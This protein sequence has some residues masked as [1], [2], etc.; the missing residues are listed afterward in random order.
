M[1]NNNYCVFIISYDRPDRVF[2]VNSLKEAGFVGEW[3]VV[4]GEDDLKKEK[5]IENFKDRLI[6]FNKNNYDWVDLG[7]NFLEDKRV[8]VYVRNALYDIAEKLGYEYFFVFDDDYHCFIWMCDF[9]LNFNHLKIKNINKLFEKLIDFYKKTSFKV[10]ALAQ[11]GDFVGGE[12]SFYRF[13][14]KEVGIR[15]K[16][17][18]SFLC[19]VRRR[20]KW[21]GR[22]N[23]DVNTYCYWGNKGDLFL[24]VWFGAIVQE[25][26]QQ[27]KG[28]LTGNYLKF[29]T[30][31]KSF[32]SVMYC[33]SA[34]KISFLGKRYK[35][36]HH[37]IYWNNLV[38]M[39]LR[40]KRVK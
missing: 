17:M 11:T 8:P 6:I 1:V 12:E 16:V 20:V 9:N 4:I 7:D 14:N 37:R 23:E 30:H 35:R 10:I 39:I 19:S 27:N 33:P 34:V 2:T 22:L 38:P 13:L 18:N 32:I 40:E 29:G 24:T 28:G 21:L 25:L 31:Y 15:R 5:Y 26:T 3:F 36:I